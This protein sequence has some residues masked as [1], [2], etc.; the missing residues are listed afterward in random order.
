MY[1]IYITNNVRNFY[2]FLYQDITL[3]KRVTAI[4][5]VAFTLQMDFTYVE[6]Y[7][8]R[9]MNIND[10]DLTYRSSFRMGRSRMVIGR[11]ARKIWATMKKKYGANERA[12]C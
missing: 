10:L 2:W 5:Q 9:G 12:K 1:R 7:L 4:T 11:V 3:L 8:S 6:Y